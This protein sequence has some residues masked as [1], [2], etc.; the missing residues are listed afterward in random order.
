MPAGLGF[1]VHISQCSHVP[2]Q[3]D[4]SALDNAFFAEVSL[5]SDYFQVFLWK[6]IGGFPLDSW[7]ADRQQLQDCSKG[8]QS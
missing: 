4:N 6:K 8:S 7:R 5:W 3:E 1:F 2:E